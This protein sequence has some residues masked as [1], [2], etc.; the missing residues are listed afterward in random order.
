MKT[1]VKFLLCTLLGIGLLPSGALA[2]GVAVSTGTVGVSVQQ[3]ADSIKVPETA[4]ATSG[5]KT[6]QEED[7]G[8][9]AFATS[10]E[11]PPSVKGVVKKLSHATKD[12]TLED[13]NAAREAVAKLDILID[14]EKRL[15]DLLSIRQEREEKVGA[16]TA[17]LPDTALAPPPLAA[18]PQGITQS[19]PIPALP[20]VP[21]AASASAASNESLLDV[22]RI[23]GASGRYVALVKD[24]DGTE[25]QVRVGD[26]IADG[27][28][29]TEI[30]K[31]GVT[32]ALEGS[33]KRT[34]QVKDVGTVFSV[35]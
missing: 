18:P 23:I 2:Q 26:T 14:I 30:S 31:Q 13:L 6:S 17:A 3:S 4:I 15:N 16:I 12:V 5:S 27:S 29:V 35:R 21:S 24:S 20:N 9:D 28:S 32:L 25:K 19:A 11:V 34:V 22:T 10:P 1:A 8:V 33:K 7:D